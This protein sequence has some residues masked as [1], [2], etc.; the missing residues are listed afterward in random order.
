MVH[1]PLTFLSE[2][3][4]FP[5]EPCLEYNTLSDDTIDSVIQHGEVGR[6]KNLSAP[7][8]IVQELTN[9]EWSN[10]MLFVLHPD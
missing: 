1:V 10:Q 4:E 2:W 9:R 7:L 3:H 8:H 5:S 6:A